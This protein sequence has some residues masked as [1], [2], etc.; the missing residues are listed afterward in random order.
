MKIRDFLNNRGFTLIELLVA[1]SVLGVLGVVI[2]SVLVQSLKGE[3]KVQILN[4]TK[5]SAQVILDRIIKDVQ[6][7]SRIYCVGDEDNTLGTDSSPAGDTEDTIVLVNI[8]SATGYNTYNRYRF[9]NEVSVGS[10]ANGYITFETKSDTKDLSTGEITSGVLHC[11]PSFSDNQST[12]QNLTDKDPNN[13]ISITYY[14]LDQSSSN[15]GGNT[16]LTHVFWDYPAPGATDSVTVKFRANAGVSAQALFDTSEQ[17][18]GQNG[19]GFGSTTTVR[20]GSI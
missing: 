15:P 11:D 7:A 13:G 1:V 20:N 2:T 18:N 3:K 4:Q 5:Q 12:I 16:F 19:I 6:G 8:D 17:L 10:V 9:W 14:G